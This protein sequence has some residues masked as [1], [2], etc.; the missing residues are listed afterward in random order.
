M[1]KQNKYKCK[2]EDCDFNDLL[3]N[4]HVFSIPCGDQLNIYLVCPKCGEVHFCH[5]LMHPV[6]YCVNACLSHLL[7]AS[8]SEYSTQE[9]ADKFKEIMIVEL[10]LLPI[11]EVVKKFNEYLDIPEPYKVIESSRVGI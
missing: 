11:N 7:A 2:G 6:N 3:E 4:Y 9:E 10:G 8:T 1:N 5:H